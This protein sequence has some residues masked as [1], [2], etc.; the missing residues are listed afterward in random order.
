MANILIVGGGFGGVLPFALR[1]G[2]TDFHRAEN[3]SYTLTEV[4]PLLECEIDSV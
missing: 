3:N 1:S 4:S 2:S